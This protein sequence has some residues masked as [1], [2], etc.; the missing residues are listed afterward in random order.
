MV[1][2][3]SYKN[4]SQNKTAHLFPAFVPEYLGTEIK[5][6]EHYGINIHTYL[7]KAS[8]ITS[9]DLCNFDIET[10]NF[11]DNQLI[12]QYIPYIISCCISD[13]LSSRNIQP[14]YVASYSMGIYAA[15]YHCGSVDFK[16]G[17]LMIKKAYS[18][19][20]NNLPD[21][22]SSMCVIGGLSYEDVEALIRSFQADVFIINQNSEFSFLLS[23]N[24]KV[25]IKVLENATAIGALQARML[26]VTHPY[27]APFLK[28]ASVEF[29]NELLSM[30]ITGNRYSLISAI[31][32]HII[33]N[34]EEIITEL[35]R[36]I[37]CG[38]NWYSLIT[39]LL[40]NGVSTFIECGAG[41]SLY[42]MGKFIEG[43]FVIYNLKKLNKVC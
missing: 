19:V 35:T 32:N 15:L 10:N 8:E 22:T 28:N 18:C 9:M 20:E 5:T 43:D 41:E 42:K 16:T 13:I 26:P 39:F 4:P 25:L 31:D 2:D 17:L 11:L 14:D 30:K 1:P 12:S 24:K 3:T 21:T 29:H 34:K 6:L 33:I 23:G 27:H 38:F 37:Y 40:K 36:N 7:E